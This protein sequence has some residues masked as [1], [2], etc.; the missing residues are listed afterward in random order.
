MHMLEAALLPSL[1]RVEAITETDDG[2]VVRARLAE[3]GARCPDCGHAATRVQSRYVRTLGDVP[4]AGRRACIRVTI[5]GSVGLCSGGW[6]W[7]PI[8]ARSVDFQVSKVDEPARIELAMV[9]LDDTFCGPAAHHCTTQQ[10]HAGGPPPPSGGRGADRRAR[11]AHRPPRPVYP[12][13][14]LRRGDRQ[15]ARGARG[16]SAPLPR[17]RRGILLSLSGAVPPSASVG[18]PVRSGT[19][20]A[21]PRLR[22]RCRPPPGRRV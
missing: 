4:W 10:N 15:R 2:V 1:L 13:C 18:W 8:D 6:S 7:C 20:D 16:G 21:R 14:P 11:G 22:S 19:T 5:R 9:T 17:L 12:L 3:G